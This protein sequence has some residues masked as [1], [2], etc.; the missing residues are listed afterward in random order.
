MYG[1]DTVIGDIG[2][3]PKNPDK[4]ISSRHLMLI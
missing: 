4:Y 2:I 1:F 3:G